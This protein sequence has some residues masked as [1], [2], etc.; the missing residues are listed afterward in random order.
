MM[1]AQAVD[2]QRYYHTSTQLPDGRMSVIVDVG[3]WLNLMGRALCRQQ[4]Q[5][6]I[7]AGFMPEQW[8]MERPL[9]IQG[10]GNGTQ[11]CNWEIRLPIAAEDCNGD[12]HV[13]S[14]ET[15]IVEGTGENIPGLLGLKSIREKKGVLETEP[16]KEMLTFPGPGGY[17]II[18]APGYQQFKL[19]QAPS[20]HLVIPIS[21][22]AK[23][24]KSGGVQPPRTAF[25]TAAET[26]DQQIGIASSSA[27]GLASVAQIGTAPRFQ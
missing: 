10:V 1:V 14:F 15:P 2:S 16:G 25:H 20:G 19:A 23:V 26:G 24:K 6:A 7:A 4:A 18:F 9:H 11:Q 27:S 13:H 17:E 12:T 8:K 3:A 22:F 21:D 5:L